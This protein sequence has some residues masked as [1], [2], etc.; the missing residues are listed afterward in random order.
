M[1]LYTVVQHQNI[2]KQYRIA[3]ETKTWL[4]KLWK[5][6]TWGTFS[7]DRPISATLALSEFEDFNR[8]ILVRN[9]R[10]KQHIFYAYDHDIQPLRRDW[11]GVE[12]EHIH[13]AHHFEECLP[14]GYM[15]A[16]KDGHRI[17]KPLN[18][19]HLPLLIGEWWR[20]YIKSNSINSAKVEMYD[21]E[22]GAF[23]YGNFKHDGHVLSHACPRKWRS[24]NR[25][26][27]ADNKARR[28]HY[29]KVGFELTARK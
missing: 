11:Y 29:D 25:K 9:L 15:A 17:L 16:N 20:K 26:A 1:V 6:H 18:P 10:P 21:P 27:D 22:R 19:K 5:W 24:C 7:F 12:A 2:Q 28:C 23:V 14:T 4:D 8:R 3:K 13:A